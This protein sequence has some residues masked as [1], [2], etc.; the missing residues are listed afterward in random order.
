M[1]LIFANVAMFLVQG[2]APGVER[3]LLLVPALV[4]PLRPWTIF[5]YMFLHAGM[6]H[7]IFNMIG[8]YFFGPRLEARL[9][10]RYFLGLYL[11]SGLV[12]A[13]ASII[14]PFVA[15]VG[16]SGAVFGVLLGYARYW[17]RDRIYIWG[18]LPVEARVMVVALTALSIYG[19]FS[20]GGRTA[21][22]A[23]LGGFLG[24]YLYLKWMERRSPARL[25][26]AKVQPRIA[27]KR[28]DSRDLERW[29]QIPRDKMHPVN[30][31]ELD[32]VLA[33]ISEDGAGSL[34]PD[35]K[36]FL[37]RFSA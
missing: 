22:F 6:W 35:E 8:L 14:T 21:H 3:A 33:K 37:D 30:R 7:L 31:N 17:P 36:A 10:G 32:R 1:R 15:I 2:A 11:V 29:S 19:G 9:G 18:I 27:K 28:V 23:H 25:F 5:T 13:L 34:T 4:F 20:G 24:G 12:G 16:A 26:K